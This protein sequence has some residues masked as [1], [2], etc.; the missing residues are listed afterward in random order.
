ML[1]L[2]AQPWPTNADL[3]Y[4]VAQL[5]Y[6]RDTDI[7]LDPT[8]GRGLW[9]KRWTPGTL[10]AL[11]RKT[12]PDWDFR[13]MTR[14]SDETF[15]VVAFDPPYVAQGGRKT[16]GAGAKDFTDRFGLDD[17]AATPADVSF[18]IQRGIHASY[19]VLKPG[20]VMLLKCKNYVSSGQ[21]W[22]GAHLAWT[23]AVDCGF[24]YVDEFTMIAGTGPQ[25]SKNLDGTD[26]RQVHA[27]Q[28]ASVLMIFRK[29]K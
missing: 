17:C 4:D 1:V 2:S 18:D 22:P 19:R 10:V 14:F 3:I 12:D 7:I 21:L 26:R 29:G 23:D 9:W 24:K 13:T 16:V 20:G 8:Y 28:N 11:D 5:G 25:P 27:R 15:D 6:L